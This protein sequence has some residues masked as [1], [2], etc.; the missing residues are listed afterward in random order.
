MRR[1]G[2][3]IVLAAWLAAAPAGAADP[4][5]FDD[6]GYLGDAALL[7]DWSATLARQLAQ[8][9]DLESC[10]AEADGCPAWYRGLRRLLEKA[11]PLP[12]ERQVKLVNFYVNSRRYRPDRQARLETPLADR[13]LKYRSRW[14]TVEEFLRRGGDCEDY[15]TTKYF[16]LRQIGFEADRLRIV[17][18][19]DRV[20][21]DYHAVLAVQQDDGQVVLLESDNLIRSGDRHPYRFIY[22][23]NEKSIWDHEGRPA[24][25]RTNRGQEE[26]TA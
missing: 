5:P 23:V 14:A 3:F 20:V 18:A 16:L 7:P 12:A 6:S 10:L 24:L 11:A 21:R 19:F 2:I 4:Y 15:A 25:S 26:D 13:P 22:S 9:R 1:T 17:V 8:S